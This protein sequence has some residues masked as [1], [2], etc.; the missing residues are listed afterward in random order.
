MLKK[1][2]HVTYAVL[3]ERM[4][5]WLWYHI[6]VEGGRLVTKLD[7]VT[8]DAPSSMTLCCID[9][10]D[11]FGIALVS[12]I[13][14]VKRS[15]VSV[16][17]ERHGDHAVQ[18]VAYGVENLDDFVNRLCSLG[19]RMRGEMITRHDGFGLVKQGF[20][21]GY[22]ASGD[23]AADSFPEYLERPPRARR[24]KARMRPH[25]T[26]SVTAGRGFYEQLERARATAD[27]EPLID[28]S[29]M[30]SDWTIPEPQ[31]KTP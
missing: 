23:P 2:D 11:E 31:T 4:R 27:A 16:F 7:D 28:E 3:P 6:E 10:D 26:F 21:K 20:G 5:F 17:V 18:H 13:D 12:G 25:I 24:K 29:S 9:Y 30:P 14:R 22:A 1:V 8:P 19:G 15:Q